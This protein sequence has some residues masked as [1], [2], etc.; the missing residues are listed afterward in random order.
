MRLPTLIS[1]T[2]V[3]R[4]GSYLFILE[5]P[6]GGK[7]IFERMK[8]IRQEYIIMNDWLFIL[9]SLRADLES[10]NS[11]PINNIRDCHP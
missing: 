7:R 2:V 11:I 1:P 6:N 9:I 5:L 4:D 3:F 8:H 10:F